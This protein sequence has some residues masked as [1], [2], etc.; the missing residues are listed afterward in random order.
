M[1]EMNE[2]GVSSELVDRVE[3]ARVAGFASVCVVC[4]H[5]L[6]ENGVGD[7]FTGCKFS[8][9]ELARAATPGPWR[10]GRGEADWQETT[11]V[12]VEKRERWS[13]GDQAPHETVV[14]N[15]DSP[16]DPRNAADRAYIAAASPE[17][18]IALEAIVL[19]NQAS[20]EQWQARVEAAEQARDR[21]DYLREIKENLADGLSAANARLAERVEAAGSILN[22]AI[23]DAMVLREEARSNDGLAAGLVLI[24]GLAAAMMLIEVLPARRRRRARR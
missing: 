4:G 13:H 18:I 19:L 10:W 3:A 17:K 11:L 14:L 22:G 24:V 15:E 2:R 1:N 7:H 23:E 6:D 9:V 8:L 16:W 5:G 20:A 21:A 12:T